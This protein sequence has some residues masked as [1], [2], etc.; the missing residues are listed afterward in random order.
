MDQMFKQLVKLLTLYQ[1]QILECRLPNPQFQGSLC[2]GAY[3]SFS[4]GGG[5]RDF[6]ALQCAEIILLFTHEKKLCPHY[7]NPYFEKIF[8][9]FLSILE[10]LT[11]F[12][13]RLCLVQNI[14]QLII[15]QG[16]IFNFKNNVFP[17]GIRQFCAGFYLQ[18]CQV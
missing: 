8:N 3:E 16:C 1:Q 17:Q 10:K 7:K 4:A 14:Y 5:G 18:N 2:T 12:I 6:C 11:S 9:S 13:L 15:C